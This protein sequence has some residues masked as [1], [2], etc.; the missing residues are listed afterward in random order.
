VLQSVKKALDTETAAMETV[1]VRVLVLIDSAGVLC[2]YVY[3]DEDATSVTTSPRTL[4]V[5]YAITWLAPEEL[6][7][8]LQEPEKHLQQL[9]DCFR[10][11]QLHH[12]KGCKTSIIG[13]HS[14]EAHGRPRIT[15]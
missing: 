3:S 5:T 10:G 8:G 14:D 6:E 11:I 13:D 2:I 7:E 4:L 15:T 1:V 12:L 9:T